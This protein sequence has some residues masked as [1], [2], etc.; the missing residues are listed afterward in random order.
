MSAFGSRSAAIE[1][2]SRPGEPQRDRER[3]GRGIR[4]DRDPRAD[5]A[6]LV[7]RA[8]DEQSVRRQPRGHASPGIAHLRLV[9]LPQHVHRADHRRSAR[10]RHLEPAE[11]ERHARI[12]GERRRTRL[13]RRRAAR[14]PAR[15][16]SGS[17]SSPTHLDVRPGARQPR[18][19]LERGDRARAEAEV[20]DERIGR[21]A[22]RRMPRDPP[23]DAAQPVGAGR[24]AGDLPDGGAAR[25]HVPMMPGRRR[26][27]GAGC[28][29]ALVAIMGP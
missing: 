12:R 13:H 15:R 18:V 3:P 27:S 2:C 24:A 25:A 10:C 22:Q 29:A 14:A 17:I 21:A 20:D 28:G 8:L 1:G 5:A 16:G 19:Q 23:V 7:A 11:R 26:A 4:S 6:E 9:V